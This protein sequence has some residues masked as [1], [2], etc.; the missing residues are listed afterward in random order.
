MDEEPKGHHQYSTEEI[1]R[2]L[3]KHHGLVS[4]AARSLKC[5]PQTI[6]LRAKKEAAIQQ[7]IENSRESLVDLAE[8][9]L[10]VALNKGAPWAIA[11]VLK[12]IGKARG[13]VERGEITGADGAPIATQFDLS[14]LSLEQLQ[15]MRGLLAQAAVVNDTDTQPG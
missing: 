3:T 13:Y 2:A 4:L 15:E 11:L 9:K 5:A 12:T 7:A 10:R 8:Q 6:R 1:V 14:K